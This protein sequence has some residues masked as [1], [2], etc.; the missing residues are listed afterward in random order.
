MSDPD[1]GTGLAAVAV[2]GSDLRRQ[3][4]GVSDGRS[5]QGR[6][7]PVGVVLTLCAAAVLA[8]SRSFTAIAGWVADVP[9]ELRALLYG[10]PDPPWPSKTTLWR[11]LT[12]ADA[13]AVDAAIGAW[14]LERAR[15]AGTGP[16]HVPDAGAPAD[17]VP[18]ADQPARPDHADDADRAPLVIAVDGKTLRGAVD[19][20]GAQM[21]LM[22]AA[23][24]GDQLVLGQV[25]VG[26]KT[27]E[28]PMFAPLID[29]LSATGMDP[30]R[31]VITADALC[32][33]RHNASYEDVGVMPMCC[34]GPRLT[35]DLVAGIGIIC[36]GSVS[37]T[38]GEGR[39]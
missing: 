25:E 10:V 6:D 34:P 3:F 37:S 23:T 5:D 18:D 19:D 11:V 28:I 15:E 21:H 26:A 17:H 2:G 12:G 32:R 36:A 35:D 39:A 8:G 33:C 4:A 38:H 22:A 9:A 27:N 20:D 29:R 24:H 1:A 30:S 7:H 14:L 13:A 31:L 16:E